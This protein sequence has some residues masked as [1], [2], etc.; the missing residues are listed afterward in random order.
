MGNGI[1][2]GPQTWFTDSVSY[3]CGMKRLCAHACGG[4]D[5]E[6]EAGEVS[7]DGSAVALK[8]LTAVR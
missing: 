5:A 8:L 2:L 6:D 1:C 3:V 4:V 7:G